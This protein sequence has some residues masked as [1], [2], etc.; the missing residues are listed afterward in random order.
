MALAPEN[1]TQ[2]ITMAVDLQPVPSIVD[3][4]AIFLNED[5]SPEEPDDF[6]EDYD[7]YYPR[8]FIDTPKAAGTVTLEQKREDTR[9]RLALIY[10]IATFLMFIL[11]FA[12]AILD[13]A[14]RGT[15]IVDNLTKILPL[16]SGIFLGSL[17]FVLGYYFR[18]LEGEAGSQST[19]QD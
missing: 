12:V 11:G 3:D 18:K 16:I 4:E 10:T 2:K 5:N 8:G 13:A 19:A 6:P 7:D 17:G 14:I 9:G 1:T 15:S